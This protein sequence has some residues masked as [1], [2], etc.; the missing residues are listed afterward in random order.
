[1]TSS[2]F[3]FICGYIAAWG[4]LIVVSIAVTRKDIIAEIRK[5]K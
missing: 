4:A 2:Q 1:M 3:H 5:R